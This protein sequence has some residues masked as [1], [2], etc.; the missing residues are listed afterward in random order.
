MGKY[1]KT[2]TA[3]A[4]MA[5]EFRI[6]FKNSKTSIKNTLGTAQEMKQK[7]ISQTIIHF[8]LSGDKR[9]NSLQLFIIVSL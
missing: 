5:I 9:H 1:L 2:T 8:Q 4:S 3:A 6:V 7:K